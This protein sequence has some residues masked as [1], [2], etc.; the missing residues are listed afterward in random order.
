MIDPAFTRPVATIDAELAA[1]VKKRSAGLD[2]ILH[3]IFVVERACGS[4]DRLLAERELS[5]KGQHPV[6][7]G[8]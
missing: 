1:Q 3:G 5:A 7:S 4:I 2:E 6:G 8:Q